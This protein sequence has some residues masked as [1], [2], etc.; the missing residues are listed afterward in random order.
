MSHKQSLAELGIYCDTTGNCSEYDSHLQ[1]E[2]SRI[3]AYTSRANQSAITWGAVI[4]I[5]GLIV[6]LTPFI[7]P[8]Q[9]LLVLCL[10]KLAV[11]A[12]VIIGLVAGVLIG[13]VISFSACYKQSCSSIEE[14]AM[15]TIPAISLIA[16][17]P[18]SKLAYRKRGNIAKSISHPKPIGWVIV[19]TLIIIFAF[20]RTISTIS[21][22]NH[23]NGFEKSYLDGFER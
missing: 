20:I 12:P 3:D 16:T 18:I 8:L 11:A 9:R 5:V 17:V 14:S 4:A 13:L 2:Y 22:N 10:P 19:G 23:Y 1:L 21:S 6:L 7:R 15:L